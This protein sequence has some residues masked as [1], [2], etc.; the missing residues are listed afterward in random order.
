MPQATLRH[1][2]VASTAT[3]ADRVGPIGRADGLSGQHG[4]PKRPGE[5][6]SLVCKRQV[7]LHEVLYLYTVVDLEWHIYHSFINGRFPQTMRLWPKGC[8]YRY[9]ART[10]FSLC[11]LQR[12]QR[13]FPLQN[14]WLQHACGCFCT[15]HRLHLFVKDRYMGDTWIKMKHMTHMTMQ[16][17]IYNQP[18]P[19]P[20]QNYGTVCIRNSG[21]KPPGSRRFNSFDIEFDSIFTL[22]QLWQF[23]AKIL[24]PPGKCHGIGAARGIC[25]TWRQICRT[26]GW[27]ERE[28]QTDGSALKP[29]FQIHRNFTKT[30]WHLWSRI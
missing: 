24:M 28:T 11:R 6:T 2:D 12:C 25:W 26:L 15:S 30:S 1:S 17:L 7:C 21:K 16:I 19:C 5:Q 9:F 13:G 10:T 27:N 23:W 8:G 29:W 18:E 22:W 20:G 4:W 14:I 3:V